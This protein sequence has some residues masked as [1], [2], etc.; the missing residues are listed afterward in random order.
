[1]DVEGERMVAKRLLAA[2]ITL[3]MDGT[4]LKAMAD[5]EI[6]VFCTKSAFVSNE[7]SIVL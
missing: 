2:E 5:R 1:M 7:D 6:I 4:L 3:G